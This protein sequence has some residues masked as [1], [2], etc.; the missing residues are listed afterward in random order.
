MSAIYGIFGEAH[1]SELQSM[2]AR[3]RHRGAG[4]GIWSPS[5]RVHFGRCIQPDPRAEF[6]PPVNPIAFDGFIDNRDLVAA[7]LGQPR[8]HLMRSE[9]SNLVFELYQKLGPEALQHIS[10]QFAVAIWDP[11]KQ[12]LILARDSLAI[13]PL[14]VVHVS[15]RYLFASEYKALLAIESVP[16]S[17]NREAIQYLQRTKYVPPGSSC[18][19]DVYS[20]PSGGAYLELGGESNFTRRYRGTKIEH[21]QRSDEAHACILRESLLEA[22]RRQTID[23]R[24][25]GVSLSG[26]IDSAVTAAAVRRVAPDRSVHTFTA[27]L[28]GAD[29]ELSPAAAVASYIGAH[30]HEVFLP[31]EDLPALLPLVLW[32]MEDPIGR[33]EKVLYYVVAR[34]ASKH[35]EILLAGH[36]ADALLGG[37]PR[38]LVVKIATSIPLV[39]SPL[40]E[41][42][43]Y[44]QTGSVPRSLMGRALVYWHSKGKPIPPPS[45]YGAAGI[46]EP[47]CFERQAAQPLSALLQRSLFE[48]PNANDA[49]ERIHAASG[50]TFNSPFLDADLIRCSLETPD[51]L[52]IQGVRQKYILRKASTGLLPEDIL[53][54]GKGLPR[55]KHDTRFCDVLDNLADDLLSRPA[56]TSRGLF[57]PE[58]VARIRSRPRRRPYTTEQVYRLWSLLLTELW[59]RLFLD[60][61]GAHPS[62]AP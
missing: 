29:S 8:R 30:H 5:A 15:E 61:R 34:E 35:V 27:Q 31:F 1:P 40:Q 60:N 19:A 16:A 53:N 56:L 49:I 54:R 13:R 22:V 7:L 57:D 25:I 62:P 9:D 50:L 52:K 6:T 43:R 21:P 59:S 24:V 14:Y 47:T 12:R 36:N 4:G 33:E 26:G 11:R 20:V 10:G 44:T 42:Y 32:H 41:L 23:R 38:H 2:G 28:A 58:Y 46:P 51:R 3:L 39:R 17:P 37:M 48:G 45:V 18:L 55:F